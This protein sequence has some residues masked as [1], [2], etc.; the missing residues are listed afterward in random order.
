MARFEYRCKAGHLTE[1][2]MLTGEKPPARIYC[3]ECN[4]EAERAWTSF[5]FIVK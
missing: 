2:Q 1:I 5:A 3:V 4:K